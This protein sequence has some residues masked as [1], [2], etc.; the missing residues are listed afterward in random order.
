MTPEAFGAKVEQEWVH[1]KDGPTTLTDAEIARV[2]KFFVDPA[3][4]TLPG[5]DAAYLAA[6]A[7]NPAFAAG[8]NAMSLATSK[9]AMPQLRCR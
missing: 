9:P 6:K 3:Y 7:S 1:L 4:E 2:S 5:D 8:W